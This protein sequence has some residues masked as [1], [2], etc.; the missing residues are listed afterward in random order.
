MADAVTLNYNWSYPTNGADAT[1]WG[2]TLNTTVIAIDAQVRANVLASA[3]SASPTF[4]GTATFSFLSA[5]NGLDGSTG[6]GGYGV[7]IRAAAGGS[8][9][10]QITDSAVSAQWGTMNVGSAGGAFTFSNGVT[11]PS[12]TG[13][14]I[15]NAST[16]AALQGGHY[17]SMAGDVTWSSALF[18]GTVD[19]TG[20]SALV[21]V[22]ASPGTYTAANI[23]VDS[24][25]R[26]TTATN[27]GGGQTALTV[28]NQQAS[29]TASGE[30]IP[31]ATWTQR[32]LNTTVLNTI[33]GASL[34][35]NQITLPVGTYQAVGSAS[36]QQVSGT[37]GTARLRL[38]NITDGTTV[39]TGPGSS[40]VSLTG[41]PLPIAGAFTLA[42]SKVLELDCFSLSSAP[43]TGGGVASTGDPEVFVQLT[44]L[45][46]A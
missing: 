18:N 41:I 34:A 30:T 2:N 3:P 39:L 40:T 33:A 16:A 11:A 28:Q 9:T 17:I 23:T 46:I 45:K 31:S 37:N 8:A 15:G 42:G 20:T 4:T 1:T 13:A 44:F 29:G 43:G 12:F 27:G 26:V 22:N 14:L 35:S 5:T 36:Y 10:L 24:K 6:T 38:R 19:V 25:G 21:N 32:V 7:R